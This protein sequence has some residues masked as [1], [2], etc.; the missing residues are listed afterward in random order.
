LVGVCEDK[1]VKKFNLNLSFNE[2]LDR[3][4]L[5]SRYAGFLTEVDEEHI[6]L[7]IAKK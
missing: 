2:D 4:S 1:S 7:K 6:A 5:N 3:F